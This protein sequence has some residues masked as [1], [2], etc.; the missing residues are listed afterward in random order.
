MM[1][2]EMESDFT[3]QAK[4]GRQYSKYVHRVPRQ[5]LVFEFGINYG[6]NQEIM[7]T[8]EKSDSPVKLCAVE[9]ILNATVEMNPLGVIQ[10]IECLGNS[11]GCKVKI[12]KVRK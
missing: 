3:M 11:I 4:I 10:L 2:P 9:G 8:R 5:K 7:V 6:T 12:K 1:S